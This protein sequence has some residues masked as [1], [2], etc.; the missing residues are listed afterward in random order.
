M[1]SLT[2]RREPRQARSRA[3]F[4]T[5][6]Q[7][8]AELLDCEGWEGFNTNLL[9]ERAGLGLQALY[10]YFPNKLTVVVTLAERMVAEW[11][12]WFKSFDDAL[13]QGGSLESI[14]SDYIDT[15]VEGIRE[16]PGGLAVRR[17]MYAAPELRE[18]DQK[19]NAR[20]AE[21]LGAALNRCDPQLELEQA[22]SIAAVL[23]ESAVPV[24]DLALMSSPTDAERLLTELKSMQIR[25][26]KFRVHVS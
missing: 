13:A 18:I 7:A 8:A 10:R 5:I 20:F 19:D 21:R 6:L 11:E 3:T 2:L 14:W 15:F 25:Y 4:E 9:A 12:T 22:R 16:L 1:P 17:A 24:I 23:I 26:L